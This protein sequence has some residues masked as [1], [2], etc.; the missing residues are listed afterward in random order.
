MK[1]KKNEANWV[2]L[3]ASKG[4]FVS[5]KYHKTVLPEQSVL[6]SKAAMQSRTIWLNLFCPKV[7]YINHFQ[8]AL[9]VH[10]AAEFT[11]CVCVCVC[12]H[13]SVC[14]CVGT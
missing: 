10:D 6:T 9:A 2:I 7:S 5:I 12:A 11:L 4:M 14:L 1:K 13:I 3:K 8:E